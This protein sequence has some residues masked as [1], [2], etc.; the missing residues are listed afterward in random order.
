MHEH[1]KNTGNEK[2]P[3]PFWYEDG[4]MELPIQDGDGTSVGDRIQQEDKED[5]ERKSSSHSR[6]SFDVKEIQ[7]NEDGSTTFEISGDEEDMNSLFETMIVHAIINGIEYTQEESDRWIAE[8]DALKAADKLVRFLDVWENVDSFDYDPG[9]KDA[10]EELKNL[11][12]K[13][14]V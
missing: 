3:S 14:G 5:R 1:D 2:G 12:K 10:K 8:R 13:A 6:P 4:E 11:L 9:V 7:R